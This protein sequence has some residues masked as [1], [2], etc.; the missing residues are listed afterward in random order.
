MKAKILLTSFQTWLPHQKSNSSD[1][2]LAILQQ[3]VNLAALFF[4]RKLPVNIE[5]ATEQVISKIR[6]IKPD[7]IICCGMAESRQRLSIEANATC[8]DRCIYTQVDLTELTSNLAI[9]EVSQ[10]AGKFVCEGLYYQIL[11]YT[12]SLSPQ[13]PCIFIH[14]PILNQNNLDSI[15]QDFGLI[16]KYLN[17]SIANP[18]SD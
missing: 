5:L 12:R 14:V 18:K 11:N 6:I 16:V 4:L 3:Q 9:T 1:E 2:L 15:Q 17:E 10:D 8:Q 7:A 13:P